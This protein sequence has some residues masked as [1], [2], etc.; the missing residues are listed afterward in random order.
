MK[1]KF[2]FLFALLFVFSS[3]VISCSKK[4]GCPSTHVKPVDLENYKDKKTKKYK[5]YKL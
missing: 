3:V 2:I 4:S 1:V 5:K